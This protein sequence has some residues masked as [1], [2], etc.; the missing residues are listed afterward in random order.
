MAKADWVQVVGVKPTPSSAEAEAAQWFLHTHVGSRC[1]ATIGEKRKGGRRESVNGIMVSS[2]ETTIYETCPVMNTNAK[3]LV[4]PTKTITR[5]SAS[6]A[7]D[8]L[9]VEYD[10]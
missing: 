3:R 6:R 5:D 10:V 2:Y 9:C 1:V 4:D 7:H 8:S